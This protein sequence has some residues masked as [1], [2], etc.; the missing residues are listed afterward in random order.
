M[1]KSP[2][3]GAQTSIYCAVSPDLNGVSGKYF[4]DCKEKELLPHA[5]NDEDAKKL[6]NISEELCQTKKA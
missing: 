6:W 5:L 1:F 4:S 2:K 3:Q